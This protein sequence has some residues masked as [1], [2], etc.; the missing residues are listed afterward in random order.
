MVAAEITP[1][2]L[3]ATCI[4]CATL[5]MVV[6]VEIHRRLSITGTLFITLLVMHGVTAVPY[7][8]GLVGRDM[9]PGLPLSGQFPWVIGAS[10][11]FY[12]FG[13]WLAARLL[14][15]RLVVDQQRLLEQGTV[16]GPLNRWLLALSLLVA[17]TIALLYTF[18]GNET[19]VGVLLLRAR[20]DLALREF[21]TSFGAGNPYGYVAAVVTGVVGPLLLALLL[22]RVATSAPTVWRAALLGVGGVLFLI[23]VLSSVANLQKA[24]LATLVIVMLIDIAILRVSGARL[25]LGIWLAPVAIVVAVGLL[26]FLLTAPV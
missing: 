14:R 25:T 2:L 11:L 20:D 18:G 16:R 7:A 22:N 6:R 24:P 4:V 9:V 17:S 12:S 21:R 3:M 13:V 15:F 26:G 1:T 10:F 23:L 19:A 8:L 5:Y